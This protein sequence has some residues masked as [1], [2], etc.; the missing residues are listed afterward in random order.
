[1]DAN[2]LEQ[3]CHTAPDGG[4]VHF[5]DDGVGVKGWIYALTHPKVE[6]Y[7]RIGVENNLKAALNTAC[8]PANLHFIS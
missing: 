2:A 3:L 5:D 1:S 7:A 4:A 6:V 8:I